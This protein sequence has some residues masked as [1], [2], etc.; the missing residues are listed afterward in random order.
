MSLRCSGKGLC[1]DNS[2][3]I[4]YADFNIQPTRMMEIDRKAQQLNLDKVYHWEAP[5]YSS[6]AAPH[7]TWQR[8]LPGI[9]TDAH[10]FEIT[11]SCQQENGSI[12]LSTQ[13]HLI[14]AVAPTQL[15]LN[16]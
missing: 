15:M 2:N 9:L 1:L 8:V 12:Q 14:H 11:R 16:D 10:Q 5:F 6:F 3:V 4:A 13:R 7:A